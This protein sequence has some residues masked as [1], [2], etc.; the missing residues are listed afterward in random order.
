M[1][2]LIA[3]DLD[4][5]L[6][7]SQGRISQENLAAIRLAENYGI[8][9][10]LCTGRPYV[11]MK[12]FVEEIGFSH[13]EDYIITFN[14][15]QIQK[16]ADGKVIISDTLSCED[17]FIW[18]DEMQRL[19]LPMNLI[20]QEYVYEPL[21]YPKHY[22]SLYTNRKI[23]VPVKKRDFLTFEKQ[24]RFNKFI[25]GTDQNHLETQKKEIQPALFSN[26]SLTMSFPWLMEVSNLGV[27]KGS[28]VRK[29]AIELNINQEETMG[30]G[31]Q[32]NDLSLIEYAGIGVA[33]ENAVEEIKKVSDFITKSNDEDGVAHAIYHFLG[34][35]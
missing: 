14:G 35:V 24:H 16:A 28:A 19:D 5:T 17:V 8:K 7:N 10:V 30:I 21:V 29:L 26:Y 4:G 3:I 31:D 12:N 2:K 13:P 32:L 15:G 34:A 11:S 27:D 18:H 22:P 20:D 23:A 9:I 33:M 25:I 6:L 1:V